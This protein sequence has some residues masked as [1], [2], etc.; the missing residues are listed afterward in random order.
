MT[1]FS[2]KCLRSF[3]FIVSSFLCA[4]CALP[5]EPVFLQVAASKAGAAQ[6][7]CASAELPICK[8]VR[9]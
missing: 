4:F 2:I 9:R 3:G 8:I 1:P 6:L 5:S 7:E